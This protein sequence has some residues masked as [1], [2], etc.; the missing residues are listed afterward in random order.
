[1]FTQEEY[2]SAWA[3]YLAG[4]AVMLIAWWFMTARIRFSET[5]NVLRILLAVFLLVPWYTEPTGRYL[6]PAWLISILEGAFQG[7]QA[8]WRAGKPL[9]IALL[10]SLMLSSLLYIVLWLKS[11]RQ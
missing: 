4:T 5:R 3:V 1:M 8:F 11:R 10:A 6:S 9:L 7:P 2:L